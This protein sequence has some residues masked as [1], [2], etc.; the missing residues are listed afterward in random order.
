MFQLDKG[1][2]KDGA[3]WGKFGSGNWES[4]MQ[5]ERP[6]AKVD[7]ENDTAKETTEGEAPDDD[8]GAGGRGVRR[9]LLNWY[10]EHYSAN[11]MSLAIYG[12]G[13]YFRLS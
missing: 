4:L 3:R 13:E 10:P 8:G 2:S 12:K 6:E 9:I 7:G 5:Q 11:R 1:L